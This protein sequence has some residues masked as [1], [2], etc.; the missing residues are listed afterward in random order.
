MQAFLEL[1]DLRI[2]ELKD[3]LLMVAPDASLSRLQAEAQGLQT[4][5]RMVVRPPLER[6]SPTNV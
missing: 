4:L 2:E 3:Q 5:G 1:I 6:K